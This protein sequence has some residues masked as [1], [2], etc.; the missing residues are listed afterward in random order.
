MEVFGFDAFSPREVAGRVNDFCVIKARLPLL[1]MWMLGMLAG[2]FMIYLRGRPP[3]IEA[4]R[5]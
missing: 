3:S 4:P 5:S 1:T 2:A